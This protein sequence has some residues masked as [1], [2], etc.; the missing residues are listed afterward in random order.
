MSDIFIKEGAKGVGKVEAEE[1]TT[2]LIS[3][4]PGGDLPDDTG[5]IERTSTA[6]SCSE[7]EPSCPEFTR[8]KCTYMSNVVFGEENISFSLYGK[9]FS[10]P[11]SET[12][13]MYRFTDLKKNICEWLDLR[14]LIDHSSD[15]HFHM[16]SDIFN[17][18]TFERLYVVV[19]IKIA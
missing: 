4:E 1:A 13:I 2:Y 6:H 17:P 12:K 19:Q 18:D 7:I 5:N 9:D 10:I 3:E 11:L 16:F 14:Y 8:I 15:Y